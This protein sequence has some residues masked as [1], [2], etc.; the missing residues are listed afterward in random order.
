[1]SAK[2]WHRIAESLL[3]LAMLIGQVY[4]PVAHGQSQSVS[5]IA[6]REV[7]VSDII[8]MTR[9]AIPEPAS[10]HPLEG[11]AYFSPDGK[12]FVVVLERPRLETNTNEFSLLLFHT[13]DV[14]SSPTSE[15]LLTMSS[16]SNR[17]AIR[18]LKWLSDSETIAFL[19]ENPGETSQVYVF[20]T[21]TKNLEKLTNHVSTVTGY[22]LT[23]D[24]QDIIFLAEPKNVPAVERVPLQGKAIV[25]QYLVDILA[26]NNA[27]PLEEDLFVQKRGEP[28]VPIPRED[29]VRESSLLVLSPDG[30]FAVVEAYVHDPPKLWEGYQD[31]SIHKRLALKGQKD[32]ALVFKRYLLVNT[33]DRSV[34]PL[35][36]TPVLTRNLIIWA[37]DSRQVFVHGTYLPLTV[38][39]ADERQQREKRKYDVA[40]VVASG[41]YLEVDKKTWPRPRTEFPGIEVTLKQDLNTPP[42]LCASEPS[43]GRTAQ[44]LDLNPQFRELRLGM[45]RVVELR[46]AGVQ[47]LVGLYLPPDFAQG[48]R[49]PLVVQTHGF[50]PDEFSMDGRSEWSSGFAAR[51]LAAKG[52][53]VLQAWNFKNKANDHDRVAA[54]R[55][56]GKT[57]QQSYKR[58]NALSYVAAVDQLDKEGLIDRNHVGIIGFSRTVCF[59]AYAL[60]HS[61]FQ[62]AAAT[63]V[64]GIDCGYFTHIAVPTFPSDADDLN[65]GVEPFGDGL[66]E[67][68]KESPSFNLDKVRPPVQLI[69]L[70]P[71]GVLALWEWFAALTLQGKPVDFIEIPDAKHQIVK[72]WERRIAQQ[73][74]VDWFRFWLQGQEDPAPEKRDQ[75]GRWRK[76]ER[77]QGA[78]P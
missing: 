46:V 21:R 33:R 22:D 23:A 38:D 35:L 76:L 40:I 65:G 57:P 56:L 50:A 58:F 28:P 39:D 15:T 5:S 59:V 73:A 71:D 17:A 43:S 48:R 30:K 14:F 69:G 20:N 9:L 52:I 77:T 63:L 10:S 24:T 8:G 29:A 6:K 62:F 2:F 49:Y 31:P 51:A 66:A 44:L 67:W 19:G 45:V 25:S 42:I 74:L 26:G 72:P 70:R 78:Q 75:Y 54:D 68:L 27:E 60:T 53:I 61:S 4:Y 36:N 34:V 47:V 11:S 18:E 13:N 7:T 32:Q 37:P 1:M 3:V 64:D 41:E 55:K 16:S 12:K